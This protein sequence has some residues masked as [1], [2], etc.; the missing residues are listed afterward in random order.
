MGG[1]EPGDWFER[2]GKA[3]VRATG[4]VGLLQSSEENHWFERKDKA[5]V[6]ATGTVGLLQSF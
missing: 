3:E 2:K 1:G 4:T 5:E 6:R